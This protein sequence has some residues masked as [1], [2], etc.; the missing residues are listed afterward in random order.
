ML[1][2]RSSERC[3]GR[4]CCVQDEILIEAVKQ[5]NAKNWKEIAQRLE[6]KTDVQCLHRYTTVLDP[7]LH[8][9]PWT[10]EVRSVCVCV[11]VF[12][13]WIRC[14]EACNPWVCVWTGG[15]NNHRS[16]K[17]VRD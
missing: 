3:T 9:G 2:M 14:V 6:G 4:L 10:P 1:W 15:C 17:T 16:R 8:K 13:V 7:A 12:C 11:C 5:H